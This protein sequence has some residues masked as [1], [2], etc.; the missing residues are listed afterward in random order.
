MQVDYA[1]LWSSIRGLLEGLL[2]MISDVAHP[3][4]GRLLRVNEHIRCPIQPVEA[5]V[6]HLLVDKE[7][8]RTTEPDMMRIRL[9]HRLTE[10]CLFRNRRTL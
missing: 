6:A 1:R 2:V 9:L 4:Q 3:C 5:L 7:L 10:Y 8:F